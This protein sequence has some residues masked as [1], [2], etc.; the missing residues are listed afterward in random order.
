[1]TQTLRRTII[2]HWIL[3]P[4]LIQKTINMFLENVETIGLFHTEV[5]ILKR[6]QNKCSDRYI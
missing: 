3:R 2:S 4:T 6:D 1:M 5:T